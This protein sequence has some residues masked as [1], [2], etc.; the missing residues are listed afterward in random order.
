MENLEKAIDAGDPRAQNVSGTLFEKGYH[1][2]PGR[3]EPFTYLWDPPLDAIEIDI[4]TSLPPIFEEE[5]EKDYYLDP[6]EDAP[7]SEPEVAPPPV[8][9]EKELPN[10]FHF[11]YEPY[12]EEE[13]DWDDCKDYLP[14]VREDV[15]PF[16]CELWTDF[17]PDLSTARLLYKKA[18]EAGYGEGAY[19]YGRMCCAG[20]GGPVDGKTGFDYILK[21]LHQ[22][23]G[24]AEY[25]WAD[26][27]AKESANNKAEMA[28]LIRLAAQHYQ[29]EAKSILAC[30]GADQSDTRIYAEW[31]I[32]YREKEQREW[33]ASH[34]L[35]RLSVV[36]I[37]PKQTPI[38]VKKILANLPKGSQM[39]PTVGN[40][41]TAIP[42][43]K[44]ANP[45]FSA[46]L[47][48]Y[49]R[50]RFANEAPQVYRAAHINRKTYSAI[51][52]NELR[53][54]SKRTA[55]LFALALKL[56]RAEANE[57][58]QAAGFAFSQSIREDLIVSACIDAGIHD[59]KQVNEI[60]ISHQVQPL[61]EDDD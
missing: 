53:P 42:D 17:E 50:D 14:P 52:G 25:F 48:K 20:L 33:E 39:P 8:P 13:E 47:I 60:L 23:N 40:H 1:I 59:V 38:D 56:S 45:S 19:N 57:L 49:V 58:L 21:A 15:K 51:V 46:L 35:I 31:L 36:P 5:E 9:E 54:V 11:P 32:R 22:G 28:N 43:L 30:C 37:N 26:H 10:P 12:E 3:K 24:Q 29:Q 34:D 16:L 41:K 27:L 4:K 6:I 18:A 55:E 2:L 7:S 44:R 61:S